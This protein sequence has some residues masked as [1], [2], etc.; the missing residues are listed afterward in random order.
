MDLSSTCYRIIEATSRINY[1]VAVFE[2]SYYYL[3]A[4]YTRAQSTIMNA[5]SAEKL[6]KPSTENEID[7]RLETHQVAPRTS[8][9]WQVTDGRLDS[10]SSALT[11]SGYLYDINN[12]TLSNRVPF[13]VHHAD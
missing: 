10:C 2:T 4:S 3:V 1:L 8:L 11:S 13:T 9:T 5:S 6:D 12:T 7:N